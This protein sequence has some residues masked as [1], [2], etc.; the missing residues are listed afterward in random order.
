ISSEIQ[1]DVLGRKVKESEPYFEGQSVSQWNTIAYDDAT[2]PAKI[3]ATSFTGKQMQT[4]VSGMTNTVKELN[5]YGRT[6]SQYSDALGNIIRTSDK[7]GTISFSYDAA[8]HQIE[9][10]Y[11]SNSVTTTYD[12]WGRKSSFHDPANGLYKYE[13]T[14][15]GILKKETS[16]KGYKEY[17][18]SSD[19]LLSDVREIS[20]DGV[21][22]QKEYSFKYN[23]FGQ[24]IQKEGYANGRYFAHGL[25]YDA[26]GR[27][28]DDIENF[29]KRKFY[30][31]YIKYDALGRISQ[32]TQGLDSGGNT[33]Q[34]TISN[35]YSTSNGSLESITDTNSGKILWQLENINAKGQVLGAKLGNT[36]I[37]NQY[38]NLGFI[39][40]TSHISGNADLMTLDYSFDAIKNELNYRTHQNFGIDENFI[41][42]DNNRLV[43]WTNPKTGL[44]SS[45]KYDNTGR[46]IANDQL[47][48]VGFSIGGSPYR[49]MSIKLNPQG[50]ENYDLNGQSRLLQQVT[51]NEN[52]DPVKIDGTRGDYDFAYGLSE[53]RQIMYYGGNFKD[54]K[55]APYQKYYSESGD[56]E[57]IVDRENGKEKH[58]LYIEGTPY[59]SNIIFTRNIGL[60]GEGYKFLHKDYLGSILAISNENGEAEERRHYDAWGIFTHLQIKEN[61]ILVGKE[62][63]EYLNKNPSLIVDRG[64][65]SHE[66]LYAVELIHMNGRLY[67]P[68]LRRFLNADENIQD[69]TNTQNYNKYGYVM[70][71]PLMY[72][73]PSGE[74]FQFLLVWGMSTFWATVTTGAIVGVAISA[75]VYSI[76]ALVTGSWSWGGFGKSL[77][78]GAVT[79]AVSGG[80]SAT[81]AATGFNG[82]VVMGSINGAIGGSVDALINGKSFARGFYTGGLI[83]AAAGAVSYTINYL[84]KYAGMKE[85]FSYKREG[86][87]SSGGKPLEYSNK[88]LQKMRKGSFSSASM[89]KYNV[90]KDVVG[91]DSYELTSDGFF[92]TTNGK[93]YAYTPRPNFFTGVSTIH[94]SKAAF[95]SK[96]LLF[97]T[98]VHETGHSYAM[99]AG[100]S[101]INMLHD[102]K[103]FT[104]GYNASVNTLGHA[105]IFDLENYLSAINNFPSNPAIGIDNDFITNAIDNVITGNNIKEFNILRNFLLPVFNRKMGAISPWAY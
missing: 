87:E 28:I 89:Q 88:T 13:Y 58:I 45:N 15:F 27:L 75:G 66:H 74:V 29:E 62:V 59:E 103:L 46:I 78:V 3:T 92:N 65:T 57:I 72:N 70:N 68:L 6:N 7:G 40:H 24:M 84:V 1:Y 50:V 69:P 49:V 83:G 12:N 86:S 5:G 39:A 52:N 47:G 55:E 63:E 81:Y 36:K 93:A 97:T 56:A 34:V 99:Y 42:D 19:G 38:N 33:T 98:M 64:Y 77:L 51:Y 85:E 22:T 48:D 60:D 21:S 2:Y 44:I 11:A 25:N 73:D 54:I 14:G 90:G 10:R 101:Y 8:G 104:S 100:N 43:E 76:K 20:N 95:A 18:Y 82:A 67:D 91:S 79:G 41:Y 17:N 4:T 61:H 23:A 105:A 31:K 26:N 37:S 80:L 53:S 94:Y 102:K 16:P 96:E 71:N 32:Y 9:A 35:N 30:K